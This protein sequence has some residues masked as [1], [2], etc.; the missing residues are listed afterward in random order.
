MTAERFLS[1]LFSLS[2][3]GSLLFLVWKAAELFMK[4]RF[5]RRFQYVLLLIVVLR[6][7]L[8]I[9]PAYSFVGTLYSF[10]QSTSAYE[11]ILG[12]PAN[13]PAP[14]IIVGDNVVI[15][16]NIVLGRESN[17]YD[18]YLL[19]GWLLIAFFL[20]VQKWTKYQSFKKYIRSDWRPVE[21]PEVL[22]IL[23]TVCEQN[24][25]KGAVELYVTPLISSPLLLGTNKSCIVLPTDDLTE[26][27][28]YAILS[29]EMIHY[30]N[31]DLIYKW[32]VQFTICVH[33]FNPLVYQ[34]SKTVNKSCEYACDEGAIALM[35]QEEH[36][37]YGLTLIEMTKSSG[38]Y[39]E[40]VASV[41]LYENAN[42]IKNRLEAIASKHERKKRDTFIYLVVT[43]LM[44]GI[45]LALG[46]HTGKTITTAETEAASPIEETWATSSSPKMIEE[47]LPLGR[48]FYKK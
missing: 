8:P 38:T 33:W 14:P 46:A 45:A 39:N 6:F 13:Q 18:Q 40:K 36:Y 47:E 2:I 19:Y 37:Q 29:H 16:D 30:K 17:N 23:S 5:S 32:L 42:E 10:I 9:T 31:K 4:K 25:I 22:D 27:Q 35:N 34:L 44:L 1:I 26:G 24:N 3:S 48:H 7:L 11:A 43:L 41:T 28:L 12:G 21:R 15:G 20:L